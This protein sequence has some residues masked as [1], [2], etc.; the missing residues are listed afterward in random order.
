MVTEGA[1]QSY[2]VFI[3][4]GIFVSTMKYFSL[5]L[6]LVFITS[7][8]FSQD[9]TG[10]WKGYIDVQGSQLPIVFHFY[11]DSAGRIDGNW[12]SPKQNANG[13]TFSNITINGDSIIAEIKLIAGA[14]KGKFISNDSIN[15]IWE[16][17]GVSFPLHFVRFK[18]ANQ[19]NKKEDLYPGEKEITIT[20]ASGNKIYGTL[21]SKNNTQSLAIIIA[22]SGPTD[23]DGN[24][25]LS[26]TK[27]NQ[28]KMLAHALDT[29][30]IASFRFDKRGVGKSNLGSNGESNLVFEDYVKDAEKIFNFLHD[31]MG[32]RFVY[33]IGH[34]EG[35]LIGMLASQKKKVSGFISVAGAGRPIDII[36]EEQLEKQPL[37]DSVK[38]Q[39]PYIF[40]ELKNGKTTNAYP[41]TLEMIFRKSVQ[42]YLISWMKYDPAR[43]IQKLKC[44]VLILQGSCDIQVTI[45][46]ADILHKGNKNSGLAII[47]G[48][49]HTLKNA[50]KDCTDNIKSYTDSTMPV[51]RQLVNEIA[52]FMK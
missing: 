47:P 2:I 34:S 7:M 15:G 25:G 13:L 45:T 52:V 41:K 11:K 33:F 40:N 36:L 26:I 22:G 5:L 24:S 35:S 31:T 10:D 8:S 23:R 12:D 16:Q 29:Q 18:K 49:T 14:Y 6:L 44:P 21:L 46:D 43:E 30:N 19:T 42:P 28:Y 50:G 51:D 17:R 27:T 38:T 9:I 37:P 1:F 32:F 20:G 4:Y 48:M 39:L 3:L